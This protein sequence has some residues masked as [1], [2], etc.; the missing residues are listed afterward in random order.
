MIEK[1]FI[2]VL[3]LTPTPELG[4]EVYVFKKPFDTHAECYT[5]LKQNSQKYFNYAVKS[6][7]GRLRPDKANCIDGGL[8][9]ELFLSDMENIGI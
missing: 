3:M 6:Y 1:W 2:A 4:S 8:V 7:N 5:H 9:K